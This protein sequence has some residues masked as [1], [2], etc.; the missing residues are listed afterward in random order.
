MPKTWRDKIRASMIANRM[1]Q[2]FNGEVDL[3]SEQI[4]CG[5]ALFKRLEPE[6]SRVESNSTIKGNVKSVV[7]VEKLSDNALK[8]LVAIADATTNT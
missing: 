2:C 8:E 3:T 1:F 6:L 4:R 7:Q 5:E